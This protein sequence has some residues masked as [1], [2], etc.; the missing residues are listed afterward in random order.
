MSGDKVE[1]ELDMDTNMT[2]SNLVQQLYLT[3]LL[4]GLLLIHTIDI[5]FVSRRNEWLDSLAQL[6]T[7]SNSS[8]K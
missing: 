8:R 7:K 3:Q 4:A 6:V 2:R 1:P 5:L